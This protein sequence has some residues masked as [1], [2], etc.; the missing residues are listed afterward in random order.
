DYDNEGNKR[1]EKNL[2][3]TNRSEAYR[4]DAKYR[5]TNYA[6]GLLSGS[7]IPAPSSIAAW[8][9]DAEGN[10]RSNTTSSATQTNLQTRLHNAAN[11]LTG[12]NA[13]NLSYDANG[14]LQ[15]DGVYAYTYD[16]ENRLLSVIRESD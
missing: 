11:Q 13:T 5:L 14:N 7:T 15:D 12:I 2:T 4:Y 3:A 8:S 9:L 1:F 16:E 6:V 10:W